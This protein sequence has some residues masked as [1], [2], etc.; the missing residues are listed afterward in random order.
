MIIIKLDF[1]SYAIGFV[2][3]GKLEIVKYFNSYE[4]A[5]KELHYINGGDDN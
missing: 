3:N 5:S 4:E 2:I 1:M